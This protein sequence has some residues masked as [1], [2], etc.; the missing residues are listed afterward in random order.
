MTWLKVGNIK[1]PQGA[2]GPEG[3]LG[4]TGPIGPKGTTGATGPTGP[5]GPQG[6][7]STVPGP[8][9]PVGPAGATGSQGPAGAT[10]AQ[11]IQGIQGIQGPVGTMPTVATTIT[12]WN[13]AVTNGYY[14]GSGIA[15]Q[16]VADSQWY[17]GEVVV[18]NNDWI[19][20]RAWQFTASAGS[21]IWERRK[22]NGTW[23][24]WVPSSGGSTQIVTHTNQLSAMPG[25]R[26]LV[27]VAV[28]LG[29]YENIG[30][31]YDTTTAKWESDSVYHSDYQ[32]GNNAV[33]WDR[34]GW[35]RRFPWMQFHN[36]GLKPQV[37]ASCSAVDISQD[38]NG[39]ELR[40][41]ASADAVYRGS[42]IQYWTGS[43]QICYDG[44]FGINY[45][46]TASLDT[47][48]G[49]VNSVIGP[50]NC[51]V[52]NPEVGTNDSNG[53]PASFRGIVFRVRWT[54]I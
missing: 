31:V 17:I 33:G 36:A 10:G 15:N 23:S 13:N 7:A 52:T 21:I 20:Q 27:R 54:G 19:T 1:G 53:H 32:D 48:W 2:E 30:L 16:P 46:G 45:G 40:V 37:R 4:P 43:S 44:K 34:I 38:Q 5:Q 28:A 47:G 9:G 18:H 3:D 6:A 29:Q 41:M 49:D 12:D 25:G 39:A 51:L 42:G 50:S 24:A 11:G 26:A 8:T 14:M 22:N 35:G